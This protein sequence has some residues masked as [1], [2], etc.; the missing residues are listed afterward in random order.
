MKEEEDYVELMTD[1]V[2]KPIDKAKFI[3]SNVYYYIRYFYKDK[4]INPSFDYFPKYLQEFKS[5][6]Q[7]KLF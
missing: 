7:K 3:I 4:L 5:K 6:I 2:Y 1:E